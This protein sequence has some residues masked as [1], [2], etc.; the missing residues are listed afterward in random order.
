MP[1]ELSKEEMAGGIRRLY[2]SILIDAVQCIARKLNL[3]L[4]QR[5]RCGREQVLNAKHW[6]QDGM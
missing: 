5:T 3:P 4:R 2:A 6:V 1:H